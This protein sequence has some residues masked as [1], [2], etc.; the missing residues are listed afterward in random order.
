MMM[1]HRLFMAAAA[2]AG[3]AASIS[4][5]APTGR[6]VGQSYTAVVDPVGA[7]VQWQIDGVD[8]SGATGTSFAPAVPGRVTARSGGLVSAPVW[9]RQGPAIVNSTGW[10]GAALSEP[11]FA[12]GA[13][14]AH[15]VAY[16]IVNGIRSAGAASF[17]L[18]FNGSTA[19]KLGEVWSGTAFAHFYAIP[20]PGTTLAVAYA[21]T[22]L[23]ACVL[24]LYAAGGW[25]GASA[26]DFDIAAQL[27]S[28]ATSA[29]VTSTN[30][31]HGMQ[32]VLSNGYPT[33]SAPSGFTSL[34]A[35]TANAFLG[36]VTVAANTDRTFTG[37]RSGNLSN[38]I[39]SVVSLAPLSDNPTAT[40][41]NFALAANSQYLAAIAA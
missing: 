13:D 8:V 14:F 27:S 18:S 34:Y 19:Y 1:Y 9:A 2:A 3:T 24:G 12:A 38:K 35:D 22:D 41:L 31:A 30:A 36:D 10:S 40:G 7:P 20:N 5:T 21:D 28:N 32:L 37:T 23:T 39:L 26:L 25:S 33:L 11:T 16:A 6:L 4:I 17:A 15:K 29:S